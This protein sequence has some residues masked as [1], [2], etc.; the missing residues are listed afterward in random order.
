GRMDR[1]VAWTNVGGLVMSYYDATSLPLGRLAREFVLA[2]NFFHAAFGGSLLNHMWLVCACTPRWPEAPA[3]LAYRQPDP[4]LLP[5]AAPDQR[6]AHGQLR[7][8]DQ[9]GR[10]GHELL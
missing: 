8:L 3:D 5:A 9:R 10:A 1:F 6:R 7:R 4:S 2:D